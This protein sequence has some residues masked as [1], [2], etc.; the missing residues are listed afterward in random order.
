[1]FERWVRK[2]IGGERGD[3]TGDPRFLDFLVVD[4]GA[5]R[6]LA[7][8]PGE[9]PMPDPTLP[10]AEREVSFPRRPDSGGKC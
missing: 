10:R 2:T 7:A 3:D 9:I 5:L 1:M 6:S 8:L 4:E